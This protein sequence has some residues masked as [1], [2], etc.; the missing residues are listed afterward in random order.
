MVV[1]RAYMRWLRTQSCNPP[2]LRDEIVSDGW[3]FDGWLIGVQSLWSNRAPGN[4]CLSAL[5]GAKKMG[6]PATNNSKGCGG[7]MRVAPV[8]LAMHRE[9]AFELGSQT[10]ALTHGHPS[11]YLSAGFLAFLIEEIVAGEFARRFDP[12]G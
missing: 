5:R 10:A 9:H 12:D 4:T 8:G 1:H 6:N 2:K 11:G 3:L 7:V